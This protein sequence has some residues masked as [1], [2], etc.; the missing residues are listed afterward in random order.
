MRVLQEKMYNERRY[1][2]IPL[3]NFYIF[4]VIQLMI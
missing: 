2:E 3:I 1:N 4:S